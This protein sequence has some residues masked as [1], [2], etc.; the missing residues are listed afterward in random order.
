M[1][2]ALVLGFGL[3]QPLSSQTLECRPSNDSCAVSL[4]DYVIEL[5]TAPS[6]DTMAVATRQRYQLPAGS[7]ATVTLEPRRQRALGR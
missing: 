1:A 5:V 2:A 3:S 7:A 6:G 4:I